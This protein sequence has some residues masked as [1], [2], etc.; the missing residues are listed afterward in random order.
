M[1]DYKAFTLSDFIAEVNIFQN[2][3]GISEY[4]EEAK[5]VDRKK[6]KKEREQRKK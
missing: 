4:K 2:K 5:K 6:G 3:F 1:I